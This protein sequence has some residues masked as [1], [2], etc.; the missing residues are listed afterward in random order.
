MNQ[1]RSVRDEWLDYR[2]L[3]LPPGVNCAMECRR[4]FYAGARMLLTSIKAG[5]DP[6]KGPAQADQQYIAALYL[7]LLTFDRDVKEGRA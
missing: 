2:R 5:I 3:A 4:A 6:D 7:E 1:R